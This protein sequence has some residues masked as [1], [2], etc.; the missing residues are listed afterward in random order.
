MDDSDDIED[1]IDIV[2]PFDEIDE[3]DIRV[4][5]R[6]ILDDLNSARAEQGVEVLNENPLLQYVSG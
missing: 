5:R 4:C 2:D 3:N 1:E 6:D